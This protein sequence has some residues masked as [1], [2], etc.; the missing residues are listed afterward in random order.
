VDIITKTESDKKDVASFVF[1][2]VQIIAVGQKLDWGKQPRSNQG[3]NT[4]QGNDLNNGYSTVTLAVTPEQ[5]EI[6]MFLEGRPLRLVLRAPND[7]EIISIS[8]QS[9]SEVMSK[10]G[11]FSSKTQARNIEIIH[12]NA[13]QGE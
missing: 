6:L 9:E 11:H 1:Q 12:G 4:S 8:P 7:N 13:K 5:S 2:N 10:L 3:A